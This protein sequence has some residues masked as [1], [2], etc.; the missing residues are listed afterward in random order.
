MT[1][2]PDGFTKLNEDKWDSRAEKYDK[3]NSILRIFQKRAIRLINPHNNIAFL[4]IGCGTGWAVRY[5]ASLVR[6]G[7]F[8]GID[9]SPKMIDIA[10]AKSAGLKNIE[11]HQSNSEKLPFD[12]NAFDAI[13]CTNSFH[14]YENPLLTLQEAY[15]V[16]KPKGRIFIVDPTRDGIMK[17][18][19]RFI[20]EKT[21]K[22]YYSSK[23][24]KEL[25]QRAQ[26]KD[27]V[28]KTFW[29]PEKVHIGQK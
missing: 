3:A 1:E 24:F 12:S 10:K 18:V 19:F 9:L 17:M 26:F 16:L 20:R 14:H 22:S 4:D 23:E 11:F 27:I 21:A 2:K 6:D 15:R 8:T 5:A 28:S 25:L 29:Y 13:I 7:K